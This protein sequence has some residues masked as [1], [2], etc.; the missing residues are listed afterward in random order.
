MLYVNPI[1]AF[2]F[3]PTSGVAE[4]THS[5]KGA[6]QELEH[7]FMFT[8]LKEMRKTADMGNEKR[9]EVE[10]YEEMLDDALSSAIS[11]SNQIGLGK[12]LEQQ[13][14]VAK[15]EGER[16]L[17]PES[18][19][20]VGVREKGLAGF[21][22]L[23]PSIIPHAGGRLSSIEGVKQLKAYADNN[24]DNEMR[25]LERSPFIAIGSGK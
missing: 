1:D 6:A 9:R 4:K 16:E 18:N 20:P 21:F 22:D 17:G 13:I 19:R 14:N 25:P 24:M 15:G 2:T 3:N 8:L 7:L 12:Q 11:K 23:S 5:E 10:L